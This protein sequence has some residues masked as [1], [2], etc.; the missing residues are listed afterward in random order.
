MKA[1]F[2]WFGGKRRVAA[3]VWARL[4]DVTAYAEPFAGSLA[5]LLGRPSAQWQEGRVETVNDLDGFV[6]NAWRAILH[7]PDATAHHADWPSNEN[8]LTARHLWLVERREALRA[9]LEGDPDY[10]DAKIA[11]WWLWG[12]SQWIG[13]GWCS[14]DGAWGAEVDADGHR[15]L[16]RLGSAGQGVKRQLVRLGSAGQGVARKRVDLG[17]AGMGVARKLVHLGSAGR[18][19]AGDGEQGLLAWCRALSERLRRVRVCSGDWQR[20]LTPAAL[21]SGVSGLRGIFLDPPYSA[22][23]DRDMAC[24]AT[25]SGTVAHDV[26][27][28]CLTAPAEYRI[29]LCGYD[30]EGHDDP[31]RDAGWSVFA[32]SASGGMSRD[33]GVGSGGNNERER[34][35]FS[36][37]CDVMTRAERQVEM[38]AP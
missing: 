34:I 29:A 10:F 35:W 11:G 6:A 19:V 8:D 18:G 17:S 23:A 1:P 22:D 15:Q 28:W 32:W 21:A 38:F 26:R 14:G 31:L 7:D 3:E 9:R 5:V 12:I 2:P 16:V 13:S 24:Y 30:G 27:A 4:G 33:K 25:D 36:A 37:A 20:I